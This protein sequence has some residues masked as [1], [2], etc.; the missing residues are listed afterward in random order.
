VFVTHMRHLCHTL[1]SSTRSASPD[2]SCMQERFPTPA[3]GG[4]GA[5]DSHVGGRSRARDLDPDLDRTRADDGRRR[6]APPRGNPRTAT[7]PPEPAVPRTQGTAGGTRR[8]RPPDAMAE[9]ERT[10]RH[11]DPALTDRSDD[12]RKWAGRPG[13]VHHP[14]VRIDEPRRSSGPWRAIRA[15]CARARGQHLDVE[16]AEE[17][18]TRD[19]T[20]DDG[21]AHRS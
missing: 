3:T 7:A 8:R 5:Q 6:T 12:E 11:P 20:T 1:G 4:I 14:L 16:D 21:A 15:G 19:R 2:A 9:T 17:L 18:R 13:V 10:S